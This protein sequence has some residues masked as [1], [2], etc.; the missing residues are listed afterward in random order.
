MLGS[1]A[2][3]VVGGVI[4]NTLGNVLGIVGQSK[5]ASASAIS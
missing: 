5:A 4:D 2:T 3:G 1:A